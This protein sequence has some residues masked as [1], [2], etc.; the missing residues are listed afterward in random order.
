[1]AVAE[2]EATADTSFDKLLLRKNIWDAYTNGSVRLD[3]RECDCA[4]VMAFL[5]AGKEVPW[6]LW[7]RLFQWLGK[8]SLTSGKSAAA[9]KA[10]ATSG[11]PSTGHKWRILWFASEVERKFPALGKDLGPEHLNGGYTMPCNHEAVVV[12]RAE[13]GTRVLIHE[14]LHAACLDPEGAPIELKEAT[15]ESWAELFLVALVGRGEPRRTAALWAKQAQ[16]IRDVNDR[17]RLHHGVTGPAA[18]GWRYMV[19][20]EGVL[21][22]LGVRLPPRASRRL[23]AESRFT[24]G[25]IH[26]D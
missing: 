26:K 23:P 15:I 10:S 6:E 3:A 8:A 1:M 18:Y 17:A 9:G 16:W 21:A 25:L 2:R 11:K 5:P 19:G 12:Y 24:T 7:G 22:D 13:E 4:R 20:R 14:L